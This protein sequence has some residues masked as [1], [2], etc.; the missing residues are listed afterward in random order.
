MEDEESHEIGP[1]GDSRDEIS[2]EHQANHYN[3]NT[4]Q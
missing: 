2:D 1:H 3:M 4:R